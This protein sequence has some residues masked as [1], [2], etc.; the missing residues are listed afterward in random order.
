MSKTRLG[1]VGF[2]FRGC[3]LWEMCSRVERLTPV[4]VCDSDAD[5]RERIRARFPAALIFADY[6]EMLDSGEI[7]AVLIETPPMTHASCAILALQKNIHVLS[8]VPALHSLDEAA[9]LWQ[10]AED[11]DA[12]YMFGST[13]NYWAFV[14]TCGDLKRK[15]L[16]GNPFYLEAE[17]IH[18]L[19][20]FSKLT[21]WRQG[22][23]PVRYCTHSLGPLLEWLDD[24]LVSVSC[25][26][27]GSHV[28]PDADGNDA[29]VALLRSRKGAVVKLLL[30]FTNSIS[31]GVHRFVCHGTQG[32]FECTWP[33]TGQD[34]EVMF[35]SRSVY[36]LDKPTALPVSSSRPEHASLDSVS[37]H[38]GLDYAMLSDF[39][40]ACDGSECK[41]NLKQG[42]RMTLPGLYALESARNGGQVMS[43]QYPWQG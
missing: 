34:P 14:E 9:P 37:G 4:A 13:A 3:G 19:S 5:T 8:D 28:K 6:E 39:A 2:G 23:E 25:F 40:L 30:S 10:A 1:I 20:E 18:D 35:S 29:M 16:L 32:H 41:L 12:I 11:S 15:G 27:T 36:G 42:L 31:Y 24:E 38:G 43:I 26:S 21:P 22:Y 33:L 17:Y 7:D